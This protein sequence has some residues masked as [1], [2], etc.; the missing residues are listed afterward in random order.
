MMN[1]NLLNCRNI[2]EDNSGPFRPTLCFGLAI[3]FCFFFS[4][5][6]YTLHLVCCFYGLFSFDLSKLK[7]SRQCM[8]RLNLIVWVAA[9]FNSIQIKTNWLQDKGTQDGRL[10]MS[11]CYVPLEIHL[12]YFFLH[13]ND[14]IP[15]AQHYD[16]QNRLCMPPSV[17][18]A[19]IFSN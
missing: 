10:N 6:F 17:F 5:E 16:P 15:S 8:W 7:V 11:C 3:L 12:F 14:Q 1:S 2:A 18:M 4:V 9:I 13:L 19:K